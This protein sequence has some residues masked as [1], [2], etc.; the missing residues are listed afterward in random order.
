VSTPIRDVERFYSHIVYLANEPDEFVARVGAA[1]AEP[2]EERTRR[3]RLEENVLAEHSWDIIALKMDRLMQDAYL[4]RH[5]YLPELS[6]SRAAQS[7]RPQSEPSSKVP[8][9]SPARAG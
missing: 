2:A 9:A 4:R 8:S 6:M 1:L 3:R 7:V 5:N